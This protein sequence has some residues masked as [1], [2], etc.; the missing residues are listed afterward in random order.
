MIRGIDVSSY[1]SVTP[2]VEGQSFMFIKTTEG[3]SYQN[4]KWKRQYSHGKR[5]GLVLGKYHYPNIR[6]HAASEAHYFLRHSDVQDGDILILDWEW[7]GNVPNSDADRYKRDWLQTVKHAHPQ[8]KVILYTNRN[9]W[10]Y[11]DVDSYCQ[12]GLWIADWSAKPGHPRIQHPWAFHQYSDGA[13]EAESKHGA[14][15]TDRNVGNFASAHDL[16]KWAGCESDSKAH[17]QK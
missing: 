2:S 8:H 4:P 5:H 17:E 14:D 11:V 15:K 13:N 12:D 16:K 3:T 7:I 9:R 6:A 10:I 1:Q